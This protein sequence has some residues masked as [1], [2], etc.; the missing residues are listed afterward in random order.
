MRFSL[1]GELDLLQ[2]IKDKHAYVALDFAAEVKGKN[3][4]IQTLRKPTV[5]TALTLCLM[6][7]S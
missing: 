1:S 6:V 2:D 3:V 7:R 5:T 4:S